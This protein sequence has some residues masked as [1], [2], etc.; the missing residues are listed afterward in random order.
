MNQPGT[1]GANA[2]LNAR[3]DALID[4]AV[5]RQ[6]VVGTSVLVARNGMPLYERFAGWADREQNRPVSPR[7]LFRLAS[8]TKPLVSAAI[9]VLVDEGRLDLQASVTEYLP[10]F[11]PRRQGAETPITLFQL[12]THTS[13]LSCGFMEKAQGHP[14]TAA[15]VS[16][17]LDLPSVTLRENL[18]R[19]VG[20]ELFEPPGTKWRYSLATDVLG[21]VLEEVSGSRLSDVVA[22][23][24]TGPLGMSRTSFAPVEPTEL[25][26]AY[27]DGR[28]PGDPAE[29]MPDL[30]VLDR[31][32]GTQVRYAPHRAFDDVAYH[33]GGVGMIGDAAD[34]LRFLEAL[35]Q[36]RFPSPRLAIEMTRDQIPELEI[37][38]P[39]TGF[40]LG[41]SVLRKGETGGRGAG[42]WG[43]AGLYGTNFWVDPT[44]ETAVIVITN[45]ALEGMS[46]QYPERVAEIVCSEIVVES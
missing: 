39:H 5:E 23:T 28:E 31:E 8:M 35:R 10:W 4:E 32:D 37:N 34:Y 12:L 21:A 41:F 16:D 15:G 18:E 43:W 45:T 42:T 24:V 38:R 33:A 3:L 25:A 36:E 14:Y 19:L 1:K 22:Q 27:V 40:G 26:T 9:M 7:T 6:T 2:G 29:R 20:V 46:G 13:G 44:R 17:G 11:R 30:C